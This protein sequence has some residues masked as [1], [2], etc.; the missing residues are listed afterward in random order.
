MIKKIFTLKTFTLFLA[1]T[2]ILSSFNYASFAASGENGIGKEGFWRGI[3]SK[4]TSH[5]GVK[6]NEKGNTVPVQKIAGEKQEKADK[7]KLLK[8][9]KSRLD[10]YPE[11]FEKVRNLSVLRTPGTESVYFYKTP[12]GKIFYISELDDKTLKYLWK[13]I[14]RSLNW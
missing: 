6:I 13:R 10:T 8:M 9:I 12:D 7:V 1:L 3:W 11:I 5:E 14:E 2:L 4:I